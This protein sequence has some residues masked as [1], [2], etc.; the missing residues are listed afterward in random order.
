MRVDDQLRGRTGR[1]GEPERSTGEIF[2][3]LI[4]FCCVHNL[5]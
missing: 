5:A 1:Q 4:L 2:Q 3:P